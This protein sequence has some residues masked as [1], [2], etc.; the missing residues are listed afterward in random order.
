M[1]QDCEP[2]PSIRRDESND[3]DQLRL[4]DREGDGKDRGT[5]VNDLNLSII[6]VNAGRSSPVPLNVISS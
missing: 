6:R 4:S 2:I 5:L 1:L 3:I